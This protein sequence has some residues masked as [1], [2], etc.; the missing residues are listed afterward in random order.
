MFIISGNV[1]GKLHVFYPL[2]NGNHGD[3]VVINSENFME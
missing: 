2:C 3:Q 1:P